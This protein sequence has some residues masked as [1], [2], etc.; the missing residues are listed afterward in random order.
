LYSSLSV[1]IKRIMNTHPVAF[2]AFKEFDNLGVGY[3]ASVLSEAG[4]EPMIIDFM[5][6]KEEI[7]KILKNQKP[8]IVG[9]SVIFQNHI[10]EFK[11]LISYLREGGINCHFTA[12]G[13]YA[14]LRY[15]ELFKLIP[16][17][18]SVV[19][20]EG[21]YTLL[22]LVNSIHSGT[23]WK[24]IRS[25]A[26]KSN[27]K[28]ITNS[29]RPLEKIL[30]KF[31]VP[32]RLPLKE[33]ALDKKFAT[34]L[35]GRGCIHD[36]LFCNIREFY[37]QPPGP[38]KRIRR[39]E[40]VVKEMELLHHEKDCSV[41]LFQDDDF[42]VRTEKGSEWI[43]R[44]CLELKNRKLIGKIMWKIN[45]R[46]DEIDYDS[47]EMMKNHGLYLVFLGIEDGTDTGLKRLNKHMTVAKSLEGIN[48]LKKL[49]IGFDYG[50]ML[51]QPSSTYMSIN[52]NLD[53]LREICGDGYS[54]VTFLKMLPYF[55]TR[56]EKELRNEGRLKG[57]P[58]FLDYDFHDESLSH[59]YDF[60]TICLMDWLRDTDGLLNISKWA[61]NYISVFLHY[62]ELTPEVPLISKELKNTISESNLFLLDTLK[63]LATIFESGKFNSANYKELDRYRDDI[64]IKHD[65][66]IEL[67]NN[68]M[69][70]LLHVVDR[71]IRAKLIFT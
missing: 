58:G 43:N 11:E 28:L 41:F 54:A 69:G 33:Y 18:D 62:F 9:F 40:M 13:Q 16:S 57:K 2:V 5:N 47:F 19:R 23:D 21:E 1:L 42:P 24:K 7:L 32:Q 52:D 12:G 37:K 4:Y 55:E 66:F 71:Q 56:I 53:F 38:K 39:P 10:Y 64:K 70:K 67:I 63:D 6:G 48:I 51:F 22:E 3:L 49:E 14:S 15:Q 36:C 29:L 26:F 59:Y 17:L 44:F 68:S 65:H 46:P 27:E 61:R 34:I 45:C 50:F 25:I 35:A 20:F 31:P 8:L 60:I 30:D